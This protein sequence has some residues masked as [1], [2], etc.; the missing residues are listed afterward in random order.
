[1]CMSCL[2]PNNSFNI[3]KLLK[4]A[5]FYPLDFNEWELSILENQ[6]ENYR[7]DMQSNIDFLEVKR[8]DEFSQKLVEKKKYTVYP[9]IYILLT[10]ILLV[11][12]ASVERT[13]S[14]MNVMK[15]AS[16][17]RMGDQLLNDCLVTYIERD[18]FKRVDNERIIQRFQNMKTR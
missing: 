12:T 13:F 18:L 2:D 1:M 16:R 17:N 6:L 8:M 4:L 10:L 11:T 5:Q 3:D 9:L 15:E 7:L 14:V